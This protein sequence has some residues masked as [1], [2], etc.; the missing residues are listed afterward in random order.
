MKLN[1]KRTIIVGLAFLSISAFWQLYDNAIPI[2]LEDKFGLEA[3]IIGIIMSLDNILALFLLPIFGS[4]SDKTQTKYGKRMP[5][6]ILGTAF[7]STFMILIPLGANLKNFPLFIVAL[8]ITLL[9]MSSYRS[10]AVALMPDVTQK[11]HRS[12]ANAII[13]LMGAVGGIITL[14]VIKLLLQGNNDNY[15]LIF[16]VIAGLMII[17]VALLFFNI[18]ENKLTQ[19]ETENKVD[20]T[21]DKS[22]KLPK[23]VYFSLVLLLASVM[24]WFIS[25]N[26][27]TTAFSRYADNVFAIKDY[28]SPLLVA[29]GASILSFL[30]IGAL[31]SKFGRKKMIMTGLVILTGCWVVCSFMTSY[32]VYINV[33]L[34]LVGVSWAMINVNS[35]PMVVEMSQHGDIGKYTGYYYTFSMSAQVI[36]PILSGYLIQ[37]FGYQ[38]LF[39]YA[40]IFTTIAF[41]T[42]SMV[43]HGDNKPERR[44]GI[45]AFDIED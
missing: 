3:G 25:Y 4:L 14:L 9:A 30:P 39:P 22:T 16:A 19:P 8:S 15:T 36:T 27:V 13:N 23:E 32:T 21:A 24:C 29:T 28:S 31:S 37:F 1:S 18:N 35:Y 41:I 38:I 20:N 6:I 40:A 43:K 44:K 10:P 26:A 33:I 17:S 42:M 45:E 5:Y 12:K 11:E 2:L 34:A 7:A